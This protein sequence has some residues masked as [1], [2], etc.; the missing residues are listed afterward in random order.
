MPD[1]S[2]RFALTFRRALTLAVAACLV[3]ACGD[4]PEPPPARNVVLIVADT[5]RADR[6]GCYGYPRATSP[7]LDALAARG[8]LYENAH[9]QGCWTVPSM[10]SMISGL[11]VTKDETKLPD[12]T[13]L[14]EAIASAGI[15]TAAF[16]ANEVLV[17][18][19]GFERGVGHFVDLRNRDALTVGDAFASW[20][21]THPKDRRFFAWV[22]FIDPHQPYE[23]KP[24]FDLFHGER[25]DRA[26]LLPRWREWQAK[27]G[28]WDPT[29]EHL[30]FD[31]AVAHMEL[32]NS[33][34]DGEVRQT[35]EGVKRVL[36]ALAKHGLV[37]DTLIVFAS[38][39]GEMLFEQPNAPVL[40]KDKVTREGGLKKGVQ[41]LCANGHRPWYYEDLWNTPLIFAGP[42][43]P[44]GARRKELAQNLDI[45]PTI[46]E[47][48]DVA[49]P[50]HLQ[51]HSIFT[52][53][54]EPLERVHAY[55][56]QTSAVV[57]AEGRKLVVYPRQWLLLEGAGDAPKLFFDL[58]A[59]PLEV[60]DLA[61]TRPDDVETLQGA[62][63]AWHQA[64]DRAAD[65]Q[66]TPEQE[67]AL[68]QNG[69]L[70]G[71]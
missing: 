11:Y 31:A 17:T 50:K 8:T 57:D 21:D 71:K 68:R 60:R 52:Q 9:S 63:D 12:P 70:D 18:D 2:L 1:T 34:Y 22:H 16:L 7:T 69:Y 24:E 43:I 46:L 66:M 5:L 65:T 29:G 47:A 41:D 44:S 58:R 40:I 62:I 32:E 20:L 3:A 39:H 25:P 37:D 38:D 33:R 61:P 13:T 42:G 10:I 26:E 55:G 19:R 23:P 36:D 54:S 27:L 15:D 28:E 56:H 51:G 53:R 4:S 30:D 49:P 59:D 48:L 35:D 14:N 64:N 67:R 6:L 45:Y